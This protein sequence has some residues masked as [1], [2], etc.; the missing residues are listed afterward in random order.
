MHV[1]I[2]NRFGRFNKILLDFDRFNKIKELK[3]QI[4]LPK[5]HDDYQNPIKTCNECCGF[6]CIFRLRLVTLTLV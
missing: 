3:H 6:K 4:V 1:G 5:C 2:D